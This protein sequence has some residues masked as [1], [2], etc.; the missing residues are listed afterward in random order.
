MMLANVTTPLLGLAD[1][2]VIGRLGA[3]PLLGA[4]AAASVIFDSLFWAFGFLRMGTAALAAQALG[5]GDEQE[6][7]ATFVRAIIV[8]SLSGLAMIA[9]QKLIARVSFGLIDASPAVTEAARTYFDIR[10]WAAPFSLIN[11]AIMGAIVGRGRT[12]IGLLLQVVINLLNIALNVTLVYAFALGVRGSAIGTLIAEASGTSAGLLIM[13][14]LDGRHGDFE[15]RSVFQRK[16]LL[17]M[18]SVNRDIMIRTAALI[19]AFTFFT[20]EG[21]RGGDVTLAANATLM[22]MFMISAFFLDGFAIAAEQMCGQS[23]GAADASGFRR[24]VRLTS[25]WNL[26]FAA[27]VSAIAFLFG[28]RFIDFVTTNGD[29]RAYARDFLVFAALTPLCGVLAF[30]FDGVFTG[31]TWTRDMRNLMLVALALYF[32]AFYALR[33][34]GNAGLWT[35]LLAFLF[36]RGLFQLW[37]YPVLVRNAFPA[38]QSAAVVPVASPTR[39]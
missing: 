24:A 22:N 4:I 34:F 6:R 27:C 13:Y 10:I 35:A 23:V 36:T 16:A 8:A 15:W 3:A 30:E 39:A 26:V 32:V 38:A 28:G 14:H 7:R 5:A 31:A 20:A 37:R 19:S 11:Y 9:A 29:V 12:D 33:G 21:A 17:R 1:A 25:L 18:L 2:T